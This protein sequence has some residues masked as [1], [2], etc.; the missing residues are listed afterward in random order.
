MFNKDPRAT[1]KKLD[2]ILSR[3]ATAWWMSF[4]LVCIVPW[5]GPAHLRD[6]S[7][8]TYKVLWPL[9]LGPVAA[10]ATYMGTSSWYYRQATTV[11]RKQRVAV[12]L[13]T[14]KTRSCVA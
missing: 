11:A 10:I 3:N 1:P 14:I 7:I 5:F 2:R 6:T 13:P 8:S 12:T 9:A 4:I